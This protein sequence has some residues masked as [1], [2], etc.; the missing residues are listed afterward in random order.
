MT[1]EQLRQKQNGL[2][3][4]A[5]A[6]GKPIQWANVGK[7]NWTDH[8]APSWGF[9]IVKYRPKPEPVSRQW[10]YPEDI[11]LNCWIRCGIGDRQ[12]CLIV[13]IWKRGVI[14]ILERGSVFF[15]WDEIESARWEHSTDL[16][17]WKPCTVE[18]CTV[19]VSE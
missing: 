2:A 17:I 3:M 15:G 7:E 11:P 14:I 8:T 1:P 18:V 10:S 16:K 4:V 13:S 12:P 5:D 6:E 19:E 9:S